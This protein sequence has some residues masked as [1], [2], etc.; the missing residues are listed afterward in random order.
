MISATATQLIGKTQE[1]HIVEAETLSGVKQE[2]LRYLG[3]RGDF[4]ITSNA[5]KLCLTKWV[6]CLEKW[7]DFPENIAKEPP[8]RR[9]DGILLSEAINRMQGAM[10][11]DYSDK[12]IKEREPSQTRDE[13]FGGEW[14]WRISMVPSSFAIQLAKKVLASEGDQFVP[15]EEKK[16]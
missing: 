8:P 7:E 4:E 6:S 10:R 14:C 11:R 3:A 16:E 5:T 9:T 1:Y 2:A 15:Y 13:V 12:W